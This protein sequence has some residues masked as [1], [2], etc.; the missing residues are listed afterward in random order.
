MIPYLRGK[1]E[2]QKP[3]GEE[4]KPPPARESKKQRRQREAREAAARM[5]QR[6]AE[7]NAAVR[8]AQQRFMDVEERARTEGNSN[9]FPF[10]QEA[11]ETVLQHVS[12]GIPLADYSEYPGAPERPG[13]ATLAGVPFWAFRRW[14]GEGGE[15]RAALARA[16]DD[17]ADSIADRHLHLAQVAL[18]EP[19]LA[20]AVRVAGEILK[21]QATV[22]APRRYGMQS[23]EKGPSNQVSI[24]IHMNS[25]PAQQQAP[26]GNV[27]EGEVLKR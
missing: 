23:L 18:Q 14:C 19:E 4:G 3:T 27:V 20:D 7:A 12:R 25:D 13:A 15:L 9:P 1:L 5:I 11:A 17:A 24:S 22:R 2:A 6:G 10:Q 16:R 8:V 21:W 26:S